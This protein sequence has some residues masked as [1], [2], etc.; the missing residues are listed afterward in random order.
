MSIV[1]LKFLF[2]ALIVVCIYFIVPKRL[3]WIIILCS[4]IIFYSFAGMRYLGYIMTVSLISF[5]AGLQLDRVVVVEQEVLKITNS[6]ELKNRFRIQIRSVRQTTCGLAVIITMGIWIILKYGNFFL[7][8]I[9]VV[10]RFFN[11]NTLAGKVSWVLPLG[12]SFYTFHAVGYIID[13]YRGK[14][15]PERNFAKYLTFVS[16]FPHIIQGPFSRYDFLGKSILEE[17]DFSYDRLCE[18]CSRILWG[19]FKKL[20]VADKLDYAVTTILTDYSNYTGIHVLFA[21]GAYCIQLYADFSGY[22]D[23]VCGISHIFDI[24]LAENFRQ[25]YFAGTLDEFW[26]RWHITLGKWFKDYVF[27]PVSMG[28]IT[29]RIGKFAR[30][31]WG[32][33]LGKLIPGYIALMFVWSA[34][35]LWHGANWTY[36]VWGYLNLFVIISSIQLKGFYSKIKEKLCIKSIGDGA[37]KL[38]CILRTFCLVCMLRFFSVAPN[39]GTACSMI[40]HIIFHADIFILRKPISLFVQMDRKSI[41]GVLCGILLMLIVD[42]CQEK[43]IWDTVKD[44]C[45]FLLRN[46]VYIIFLFSI[47]LF[48]G[49]SSDLTGGFMYADF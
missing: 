37:W 48:A 35:G 2:F 21:I 24:K 5:V 19:V 8:N 44:R 7:D 43:G 14:Y 28:K 38:F 46:A 25:P 30:K 39:L 36:L 23:V 22:M 49:E 10:I 29:Q 12:M 26:R 34:T 42:I 40:R 3:Q 6:L 45:P 1:S 41:F 15:S 11:P 47:L 13:I 18:G 20:I 9:A 33:K 27:Y 32:V 16:Y 31:T 17:H 4:N